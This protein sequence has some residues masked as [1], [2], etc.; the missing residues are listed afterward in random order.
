MNV[1]FI[2]SAFTDGGNINIKSESS[3]GKQSCTKLFH[4]T[5]V[6]DLEKVGS[7]I[8]WIDETE[9]IKVIEEFI[10]FNPTP[11]IIK[12]NNISTNNNNTRK[13][14]AHI[15]GI[16]Y[17]NYINNERM[18]HKCS[19][20]YTKVQ[21][22]PH[23]CIPYATGNERKCQC[24]LGSHLAL[25]YNGSLSCEFGQMEILNDYL[26]H[27]THIQPDAKVNKMDSKMIGGLSERFIWIIGFVLTVLL[28]GSAIIYLVINRGET[29]SIRFVFPKPYVRQ[30]T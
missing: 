10:E 4:G 24:S 12:I 15:P 9:E 16:S 8:Y 6:L 2:F 26:E 29:N 20:L 5:A 18:V 21:P 1:F 27:D 14:L 7:Q 3:D 22:C 30:Q 23:I 17:L 19:P 28:L 11:R 13:L 25:D